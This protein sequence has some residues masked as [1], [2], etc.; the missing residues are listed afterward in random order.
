[1]HI[2]INCGVHM[3]CVFTSIIIQYCY[4]HKGNWKDKIL[5]A[6]SINAETL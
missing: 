5:C 2:D 4:S 3:K 6:N 1:M